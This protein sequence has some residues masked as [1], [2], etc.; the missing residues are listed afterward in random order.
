[1]QQESMV[2]RVRPELLVCRVRL[3]SRARLSPRSDWC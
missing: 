2:C 1:V 3:V